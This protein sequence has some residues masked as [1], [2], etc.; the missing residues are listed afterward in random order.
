MAAFYQAFCKQKKTI[1]RYVNLYMVSFVRIA[2]CL[3][4]SIVTLVLLISNE[5]VKT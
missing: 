3:T 2:R 5:A 1:V 4:T